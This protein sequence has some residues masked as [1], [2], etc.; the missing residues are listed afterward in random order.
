M[1]TLTIPTE[2]IT[3]TAT[4]I[5]TA[6]TSIITTVLQTA[7]STVTERQNGTTITITATSTDSAGSGEGD[8]ISL[9]TEIIQV[10]IFVVT[11][12]GMVIIETIICN[13][14]VTEATS[15]GFQTGILR[16]AEGRNSN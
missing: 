3:Q 12:A 16:G 14:R 9:T 15:N 4:F 8:I 2:T 6:T 13:K 10:L 1:T 5:L 11:L 7:I